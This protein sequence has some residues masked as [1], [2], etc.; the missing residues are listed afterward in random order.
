MKVNGRIRGWSGLAVIGCAIL[1]PLPA[2][3]QVWPGKDDPDG[4]TWDKIRAA[5]PEYFGPAGDLR[6]RPADIPDVI[7]PGK[8]LRVGN[9]NMKVTN[10]GHVGNFFTNLSND[11]A[12]QWPGASGVEYLSTIRLAVGAVNPQATDPVA[13]RRVSYNLE[14][15]P[16]TLGKDDRIYK[17]YDGIINGKRFED[18]DGH[19]QTDFTKGG[20]PHPQIDEDFL[21]GRDNDGDGAL[22]EDYA[23]FGQEMYSCLMR[24]DTREAINS[25]FNEKHVPLGLEVRQ[26]AWAYSIAGFSDFDVVNY[27]IYNKSGHTLDSLFVGWLVDMDAGPVSAAN[28]FRDDFDLP[29]YPSGEFIH[30]TSPNDKRLQD[31]SMRGDDPT[32]PGNIPADSALCPRFVFRINGFSIS[33]DDGDQAQTKGVPSFLLVHHTLDPLG[34]SGPTRVGFHAFRSFTA[35]T[36]FVQGGNPIVDQQRYEFMAGYAGRNI[37]DETG[38]INLPPGDQKGDYVQWCSVGPYRNVVDGASVEA[39]IAFSV[40]PG[41]YQTALGYAADYQRYQANPD[42]VWSTLKD[43]YQAL[44]NAIAIQVAY[45][46]IWQDRPELTNGTTEWP[47]LTNGHGRETPLI[48]PAGGGTLEARPDCRDF[49]PRTVTERAYEWFDY[50]CDYCTGA[51]NSRAGKGMFHATWNVGAPPPNPGTNVGVSYNYSANPDPNRI[52]PAGDA[53]VTIAWDNLSEV[54]ADPKTGVFD[55]RGYKVWKAANWTRPVGSAGP[56]DDDWALLGEF[57]S[58][59]YLQ[60]GD[61]VWIASNYDTLQY[62]Q[63]GKEACPKVYIPNYYDPDLQRYVGPQTVPICLRRWDIWDHQS[64]IVIHPDSAVPCEMEADTCKLER[65]SPLTAIASCEE[66]ERLDYRAHYPVGRYRLVDREVKNGFL[67]FYSVTAFDSCGAG[68]PE[69]G[70]RR[71]GVEAEGVVPQYSASKATGKVW[72]VPNPYKGYKGIASRPSA[73]DLTPTASDPT[74]THIDFFGLP[75]GKWTIKIFTVSGDLV[76]ELRSEDAVNASVRNPVTG[77]SGQTLPGYTAQ[78]D[79]PDDGQARWNLISR[80]GQ[81]IVSGIYV[82]TVESTKGTQRGRF[83]V[84]R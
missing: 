60:R 81:D 64:G 4:M 15:R 84:I 55:F 71:A 16:P 69:Q 28:F 83:V 79:N 23:A 65:A 8:V 53:H 22:D 26:S 80:N 37:D 41:D 31:R 11:P 34:I 12:G 18:D 27:Q 7:G 38:F 62:E 57:R 47:F 56:S 46:G 9:V 32:N 52:V 2:R 67:Y 44:D 59:N 1:L 50:D 5:L 68:A 13:V 61:R 19:Y 25:T 74:G 75:S 63:I 6:A 45:E 14:W 77:P 78:E 42:N 20:V 21:D 70:G 51:Y 66:H 43:T 49:A 35:V 30:L 10:F 73:W 82:F 36:P 17:S 58:F 29:G 40:R 72:V 3:A 33:D 48:A 54:S 39:T 24:D 76:A